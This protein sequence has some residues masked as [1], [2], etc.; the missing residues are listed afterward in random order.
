ML[1]L[2]WW[3][4]EAFIFMAGAL[5]VLEL[6]SLTICLNV[7]GLLMRIPLGITEA[8]GALLGNSVG[9]GNVSLAKRFFSL[10][11]FVSFTI[12]LLIGAI[13]VFA[14][15]PIVQIF[16]D[17]DKLTEMTLQAMIILGIRFFP[18]GLQAVLHGP[19]RALG[20]QSK[21]SI[22]AFVS[23]IV[24]GLPI[25]SLMA[26]KF[27]FGLNGLM[28]GLLSAGFAQLLLYYAVIKSK[29]WEEIATD[30]KC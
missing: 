1:S 14:R 11:F 6:A 4:F 9:A 2:E 24:V 25:G 22:V 12:M 18:V 21:G 23:W 17:E 20:L 30:A 27:H 28:V 13:I 16:S 15:R 5:G 10:I 26:F 3:A 29:D 8:T 7:H 19:I